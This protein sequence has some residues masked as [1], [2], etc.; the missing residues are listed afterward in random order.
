MTCQFYPPLDRL[1]YLIKTTTQAE[2]LK[3]EDILED[4]TWCIFRGILRNVFQ[5]SPRVSSWTVL[6]S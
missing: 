2:L 4:T 5:K 6:Y 3:L 1:H